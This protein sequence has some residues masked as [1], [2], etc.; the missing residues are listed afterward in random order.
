MN[1]KHLLINTFSSRSL[2]IAY[3]NN[4]NNITFSVIDD[5]NLGSWKVY[6]LYVYYFSLRF[7]DCFQKTP[8][9]SLHLRNDIVV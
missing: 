2:A 7:I 1:H 5:D 9:D 8:L 6:N 3:L 4:S